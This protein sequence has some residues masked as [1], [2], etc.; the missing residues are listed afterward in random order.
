MS[1]DTDRHGHRP[2]RPDRDPIV[3]VSHVQVPGTD[4]ELAKEGLIALA[5][6]ALGPVGIS[7]KLSA[8][9]TLLNFTKPKPVTKVDV[10]SDSHD[11]WLKQAVAAMEVKKED[12]K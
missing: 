11:E 3:D 4:E 5:K 2:G 12:F 10:K 9:S 1:D 7:T 8:L 6:I